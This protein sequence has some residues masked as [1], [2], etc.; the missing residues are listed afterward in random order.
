MQL[1]LHVVNGICILKLP[2][3]VEDP[4]RSEDR[5]QI[6]TITTTVFMCVIPLIVSI[7]IYRNANQTLMRS[8]D[9]LMKP[10]EKPGAMMIK[11]QKENHTIAKMF[12]YTIIAPELLHFPGTDCGYCL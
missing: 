5:M 1:G 4:M 10:G 6:Y 12:T 7:K 2:K 8:L 11:H 3:F 9:K